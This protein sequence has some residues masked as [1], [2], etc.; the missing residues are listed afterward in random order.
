[1]LSVNKFCDILLAK[2]SIPSGQA[3][4]RKTIARPFECLTTTQNLWTRRISTLQVDDQSV[5]FC[6]F[7]SQ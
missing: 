7:A 2:K 5:Q 4:K 6:K 3:N 1:M